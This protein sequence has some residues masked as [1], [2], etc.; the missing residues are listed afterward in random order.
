MRETP[1]WRAAPRGHTPTEPGVEAWGPGGLSR[2]AERPVWIIEP[3]RVGAQGGPAKRATLCEATPAHCPPRESWS[4]TKVAVHPEGALPGQ[5]CTEAERARRHRVPEGIVEE[6]RVTCLTLSE[7][8]SWRSAT[9]SLPLS[10]A[11]V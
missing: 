8:D 10:E 7:H 11:I 6:H 1:R 9:I 4:K 5:L 3:L 2:R